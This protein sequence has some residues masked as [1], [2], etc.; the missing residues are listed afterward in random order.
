MTIPLPSLPTTTLPLTTLDV[1]PSTIR[2]P[3]CCF[4]T[5]PVCV[6]F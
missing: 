5:A 2:M 4:P 3:V 6:L 1:E